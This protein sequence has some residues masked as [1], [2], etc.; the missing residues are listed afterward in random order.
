MKMS[1]GVVVML[2]ISSIAAAQETGGALT[3]P[4]SFTF[5][6]S[7]EEVFKASQRAATGHRIVVQQDEGLK[8]LNDAEEEIRTFRFSTSLQ[9][10]AFSVIEEISVEPVPSGTKVK[11]FFHRDRGGKPYIPSATYQLREQQLQSQLERR[12]AA[13]ESEKE[14]YRVQYET[15]HSI[16]LETYLNKSQEINRKE[17]DARAEEINHEYD[18]KIADLAG[19]PSS[20]FSTMEAAAEK[21]FGMV[22]QNLQGAKPKARSGLNQ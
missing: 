13:L 8:D 5:S 1:I 17:H 22:Q 16:D 4:K 7:V 19:M 6:A 11:V 18:A 21:F 14:L 3:N 9:G 2:V 20:S 15:I 10:V 12:L